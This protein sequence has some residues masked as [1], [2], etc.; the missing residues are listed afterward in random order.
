MW[1]SPKSCGTICV[2]VARAFDFSRLT[3]LLL[4]ALVLASAACGHKRSSRG[5]VLP[6]LV[7]ASWLVDLD[8]PGFGKAALAVPLGARAPRPIVIALHGPADR[9]EWTCSAFRAAAGPEP[10]VLCPRGIL[11]SDLPAN[12]ARY[13]FGSVSDTTRELHAALVQLKSRF[14]AHV[15]SGAVVLA[16]FE[17]G[18]EHAAAIARE[19]PSFFARVVLVDPKPSTWTAS[20]AAVFGRQG[21]QRVLFACASPACREEYQL[22]AALTLQGGAEARVLALSESALGPTAAGELK[23][24]WPWLVGSEQKRKSPEVLAGTP[25]SGPG[26]EKPDVR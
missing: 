2:V 12:D 8:V 4:L 19:E 21:G 3:A 13:S 14:G 15:A 22:R 6:P 9:P 25:L 17:L 23:S 1:C 20:L 7:A 10:F 18:A 26:P 16:G 24:V 11:R 5:K